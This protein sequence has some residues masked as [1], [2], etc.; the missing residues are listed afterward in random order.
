MYLAAGNIINPDHRYDFL[1]KCARG[2][3]RMR[4]GNGRHQTAPHA[5]NFR[6]NAHFD[7]ERERRTGPQAH[8]PKQ[9]LMRSTHRLNGPVRLPSRRD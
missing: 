2:A 4:Q 5:L 9:A 7:D 6:H 1:R 3:L 8:E